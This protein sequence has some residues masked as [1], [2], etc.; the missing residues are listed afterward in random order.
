MATASVDLRRSRTVGVV[1]PQALALA[2]EQQSDSSVAVALAAVAA[3]PV[4]AEPQAWP[5]KGLGRTQHNQPGCT[6]AA[7]A[8]ETGL[9]I[10]EHTGHLAVVAV[11]HIHRIGRIR[12]VFAVPGLP[13]YLRQPEP[14]SWPG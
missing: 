12:T 7:E 14:P 2:R 13:Y 3:V 1:P 9:H 4:V 10:G 5:E 8:A 11:G 6:V